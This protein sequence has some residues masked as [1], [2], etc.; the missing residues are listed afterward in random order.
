MAEILVIAA[1][2]HL[3][4]SRVTA[5]LL[6]A[7]QDL[8]PQV[9][10]HDLYARYPD[11][12]IDR[13]AEQAALGRAD[14]LVWLH[15]IHWYGMTP[16]LKLWADEVLSFGWA[17]GPG[18][19]ALRGKDLWLVASTGGPEASYRPDGYNRRPFDAFL[20][21]YEQTAALCGLRWWPPLVLFGAHRADEAALQAHTAA[22]VE[23][24]QNYPRR[25]ECALPADA[26]VPADARPADPEARG[27]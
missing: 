19:R 24:L 26:E 14:L 23:A 16:L 20:P 5:R 15:P 1:H 9:V 7:A 21:A 3:A 13:E 17:Y 27:S 12:W 6:R 10:V 25:P 2:P 18:G 4:Q 22:F 8:G 11:L